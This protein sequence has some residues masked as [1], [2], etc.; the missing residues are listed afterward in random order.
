MKRAGRWS[1]VLVLA[2]LA[3]GCGP[4]KPAAPDT[5]PTPV[6]ALDADTSASNIVTVDLGIAEGDRVSWPGRPG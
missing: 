5:K 3:A 1:G 4:T 6:T 2:L